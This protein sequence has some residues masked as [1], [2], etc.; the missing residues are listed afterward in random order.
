MSK[1]HLATCMPLS[2]NKQ[3]SFNCMQIDADY[4]CIDMKHLGAFMIFSSYSMSKQFS[5]HSIQTEVD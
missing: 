3:S 4:V 1:L 2:N 5:Y